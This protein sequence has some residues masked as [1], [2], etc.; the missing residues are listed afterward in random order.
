MQRDG[1]PRARDARARS[2][3]C[4]SSTGATSSLP[5]ADDDPKPTEEHDGLQQADNQVTGGG[6]G[7]AGA[8]APSRQPRAL[9]RAPAARAAR[10]GAAAHARRATAPPDSRARGRGDAARRS[11][12]SRAPQQQPQRR[13]PRSRKVLDRAEDEARSS[14]TSTSRPSTCCSRS[15]SCRATSCSR[16]IKEVRGGQRVTSQDPEGTYQALEKFGRDLTE[17]AER[18]SS[19]RSSAATRRSAA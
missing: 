10:P 11:R 18:A 9:P 14:R 16:A 13:R 8:G 1:A 15:T 3:R 12:R 4:T 2:R 7:R 17:A 6:R 19:T 5:T